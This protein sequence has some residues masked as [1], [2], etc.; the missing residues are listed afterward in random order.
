MAITLRFVRSLI[1]LI[2]ANIVLTPL[3]AGQVKLA[4]KRS[5]DA[6]VV[7]Q[8]V[9]YGFATNALTS[10]VQL[11]ASATNTTLMNLADA[12]LYYF[13]V[14]AVNGNQMESDFSNI[15]SVPTVSLTV[16]SATSKTVS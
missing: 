15:I 10:V 6:T 5:P 3:N 8:K 11:S 16:P 9:Y 13:A 12:R 14:T 2:L 4:W 1:A 7:A